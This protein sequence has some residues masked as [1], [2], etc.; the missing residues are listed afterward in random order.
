MVS[1]CQASDRAFQVR[2]IDLDGLFTFVVDDDVVRHDPHLLIDVDE[3]VVSRHADII[4]H[5][6]RAKTRI[7][8]VCDDVH[9][10]GFDRTLVVLERLLSF[11]LDDLSGIDLL[12]RDCRLKQ[13]IRQT[14]KRCLR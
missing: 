13:R 14:V 10:N 8:V 6:E 9:C 7:R 2:E 5:N 3:S 12:V 11:P 1:Y 4:A